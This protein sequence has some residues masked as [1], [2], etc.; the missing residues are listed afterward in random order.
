MHVVNGIVS[1]SNDLRSK[2]EIWSEYLQ[3][4]NVSDEGAEFARLHALYGTV[5][6]FEKIKEDLL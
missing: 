5:D 1:L 6:F 3:Q 4:Y 2:D